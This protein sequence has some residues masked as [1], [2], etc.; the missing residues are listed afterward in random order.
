MSGTVL[1]DEL[2][3]SNF[4]TST[5]RFSASSTL[6]GFIIE[7]QEPHKFKPLLHVPLELSQCKCYRL[8]LN[9]G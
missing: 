6:V 8:K 4:A 1:T 5:G 3:A 7:L 9:S 2:A